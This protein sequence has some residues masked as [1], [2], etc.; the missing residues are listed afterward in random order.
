MT[1]FILNLLQQTA[2]AAKNVTVLG[3]IALTAYKEISQKIIN[4]PPE[5]SIMS[6]SC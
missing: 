1:S 6:L 4:L 2:L 3:A 5:L